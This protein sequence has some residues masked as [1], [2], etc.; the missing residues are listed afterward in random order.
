MSEW[1][2]FSSPLG[3]DSM[4]ISKILI[5]ISFCL[6]IFSNSTCRGHKL[7]KKKPESASLIQEL[8]YLSPFSIPVIF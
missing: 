1:I 8:K 5:S 4:F 6:K 7:N 3:K 2:T